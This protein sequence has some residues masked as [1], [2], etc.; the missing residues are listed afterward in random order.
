[1]PPCTRPISGDAVSLVDLTRALVAFDT[2]NPPGNE[3]RAAR[4][5][6]ELL[7]SGGFD[8]RLVDHGGGRAGLIAT[9]GT[10][11]GRALGFT[12]HLD[13]VPLGAADW[14]D[15]PHAGTVRDGR[16]HGRGTTD[17]KGGI[18]AFLRASLDGP[19][20]PGG[21]AL[22]LTAGEETG[23]DGAR[24][25]VEAGG[26]PEIGALVVAEPTSN[27]AVQGHKGA[28]WLELRFEGVTAHGAMPERGVNAIRKAAAAVL[29]LDGFSAG[30]AHPVMGPPTINI[31]TIAGGLNTN[32]VPDRCSLTVDLRSTPGLAHDAIVAAI[33]DRL[34]DG[35]QIERAVDLPAVWTD[36]ED[37]WMRQMAGHAAA[38]AGAETAPAAMSYFTDASIFTPVL[39]NPPTVILGPGE[40]ALAHRTDESVSIARL[41]QAEAIYRAALKDWKG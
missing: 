6:A 7:A 29:A 5:C 4:F 10:G 3:R 9:R 17:M 8:T 11:R 33:R 19:V 24:W 25:M 22:L 38:I 18:A 31:G 36:P 16:I 1:M 41:E 28:L 37:P 2:V 21:V 15:P 12:G 13:T 27:R 35:V 26:L 30:P 40:A 39:G 20:P 34:E 23:S 14:S 32:S